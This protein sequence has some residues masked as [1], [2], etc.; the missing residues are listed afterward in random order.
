M[1]TQI[2]S[3]AVPCASL[4]TTMGMFVTGSII[5]PRIFISTSMG[6]SPDAR[7][8]DQT[9]FASATKESPLDNSDFVLADQTVR[10]G[11]RNS[12]CHILSQKVLP[13][14]SEI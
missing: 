6:T 14:R 1:P 8:K 5:S 10:T 7:M 12:H 11:A 13:G 2:G 4:S 3:T 9:C